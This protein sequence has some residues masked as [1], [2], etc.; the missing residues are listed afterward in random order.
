MRSKYDFFGPQFRYDF[1]WQFLCEKSILGP[2]S[3]GTPLGPLFLFPTFF[4]PFFCLFSC[5]LFFI[6]SHFLFISSFFDFLMFFIFFFISSEEKVSSFLF[7]SCISPKYFLWLGRQYQS[8]IVSS[9]V[10]APWRCG[11]LTT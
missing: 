4:L 1:S 6:F 11:V 8:L 9:V 3:G 7:F 5:F 10:G 2:I